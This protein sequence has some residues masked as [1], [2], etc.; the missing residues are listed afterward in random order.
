VPD[1]ADDERRLG[2]LVIDAEAVLPRHTPR[3]VDPDAPRG[4]RMITRTLA[5]A[6]FVTIAFAAPLQAALLSFEY[7]G[8]VT[9]VNSPWYDSIVEVGDPAFGSFSIDDATPDTNPDPNIADYQG[10]T[11]SFTIGSYVVPSTPSFVRI[12]NDPLY[13]GWEV[14]HQGDGLDPIGGN[15][16]IQQ[17]FSIWGDP[18]LLSSTDLAP[19]PS[20]DD[21]AINEAYLLLGVLPEGL[22]ATYQYGYPETLPEAE[23]AGTAIG[24]LAGAALLRRTCRPRNGPRVDV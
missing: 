15:P 19:P 21:P 16:V 4:G 1:R 8:H 9:S 6:S 13:D 14:I 22:G 23:S 2:E 17:S 10:A 11:Q 7:S 18:D 20:L 5:I 12:T 3:R 24:A